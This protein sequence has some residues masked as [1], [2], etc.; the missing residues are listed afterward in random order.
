MGTFQDQSSPW[1]D[2]NMESRRNLPEGMRTF[3]GNGNIV[4][5]QSKGVE[6]RPVFANSTAKSRCVGD[7]F[8]SRRFCEISPRICARRAGR[9]LGPHSSRAQSAGSMVVVVILRGDTRQ[10]CL[11]DSEA[12]VGNGL[13]R[14][15][16]PGNLEVHDPDFGHPRRKCARGFSPDS[17]TSIVHGRARTPECY[18]M[19]SW[20]SL[21]EL[22]RRN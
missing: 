22:G 5:P 21:G 8:G 14:F 19:S 10:L 15:P 17:I 18:T 9:A 4:E 13:R 2:K 7:T 16:R 6:R 20:S 3:A 1:E 11:A 12:G